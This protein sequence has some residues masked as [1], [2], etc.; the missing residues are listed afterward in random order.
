M[1]S[2]VKDYHANSIIFR[3]G[4]IGNA[5]YILTEGCVEISINHGGRV[6]LLSV[7]QPVSVFGEMA[8][9]L[10][11]QKRTATA[12]AKIPSKVAEISR[13]DFDE[14]LEQSP[15]LITAVLNA[16]VGRLQKTTSKISSSPDL[17]LGICET[18]NIL[19]IH[20]IRR[21]KYDPTVKTI[22]ETFCVKPEE[23]KKILTLMETLGLVDAQLE[24][25]TDNMLI[26]VS[27]PREFLE[28]AKKIHETFNKMGVNPD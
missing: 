19:L 28:R 5:A 6:T 15:K 20:D 24:P 22:A 10:Q 14:F 18:I 9:L 8:L 25:D 26:G 4:E 11:D 21:I 13:K 2:I 1:I 12:T 27:R 17:F 23:V 3:E 16:I 7:L